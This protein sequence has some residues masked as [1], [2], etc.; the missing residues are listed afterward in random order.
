MTHQGLSEFEQLLLVAI[1]SAD[2]A[3]RCAIL[4][5]RFRSFR[6]LP[7]FVFR[8]P[9]LPKGMRTTLSH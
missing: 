8:S 3:E 2:H 4:L 6:C 9:P 1:E 7:V 5:L